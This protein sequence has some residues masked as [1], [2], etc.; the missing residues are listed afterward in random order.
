MNISVLTDDDCAAYDEYIRQH[1]C[2]LLY[3]SNQYRL[4]LE[5][6]LSA[7]S[8]YLI[9]RNETHKICG[10]FPLISCEGSEGTIWN[11]LAFYG[12]HGSILSDSPDI[13]KKLYEYAVEHC[14]EGSAGYTIITNPAQ[15]DLDYQIKHSHNDERIGQWTPLQKTEDDLFAMID[16]ATRRNIRKS[17][18]ED[19]MVTIDNDAWKFLETTHN[20]NMNAIGGNAKSPAFFAAAKKYFVAGTDYN[21]YVASKDGIPISALLI[22]YFNDVVEYFTPVTV[23]E[24]RQIQPSAAIITIAMLDAA[25]NG[26]RWWN[27]GG[28]WKNQEGVYRFKKKWGA[29]D[30]PYKYYTQLNNRD[31]LAKTAEELL[32]NYPDFYVVPFSALSTDKAV[33]KSA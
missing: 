13:S 14:F 28:T 18:Q 22:F 23:N 32:K 26:C 12:S 7:K 8:N 11:A 4:F 33:Q 17:R 21:I 24:Y 2:G 1:Q 20:D 6:T 3:Y 30:R 19:V 25:N 31:I 16:S 10:I 27:W 5:D 9:A 29:Q 15:G